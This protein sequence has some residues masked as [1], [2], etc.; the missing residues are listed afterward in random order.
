M[1][2]GSGEGAALT[3]AGPS[4]EP[5]G[6]HSNHPCPAF[7]PSGGEDPAFTWLRR[8]S[9]MRAPWGLGAWSPLQKP[10]GD[11]QSLPL[12]ALCPVL[13]LVEMEA[14]PQ[15]EA[16]VEGCSSAQAQARWR[17]LSSSPTS[18]QPPC[19]QEAIQGIE[20]GLQ[21]CKGRGRGFPFPPVDTCPQQ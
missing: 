15:L 5:R 7:G 8:V 19:H 3:A 1:Q 13:G 4:G 6:H 10:A 21:F 9:A 11:F 14:N 20:Q 17:V 16:E 18:H 2:D 12:R